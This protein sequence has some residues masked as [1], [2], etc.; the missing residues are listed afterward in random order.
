M[1]K[2]NLKIKNKS[3][4]I[5]Y[6]IIENEYRGVLPEQ[7]L[8]SFIDTTDESLDISKELTKR[9]CEELEKYSQKKL[10]SYLAYRERSSKECVLFL[11][12]LRFSPEIIEKAI[13]FARKYNYLND[14]RFAEMLIESLIEKG[15]TKN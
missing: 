14:K 10:L 12:N 2:M 5:F 13:I 4:K 15:K 1:R 3:R 6:I 11:Q 8:R 9:I 7:T